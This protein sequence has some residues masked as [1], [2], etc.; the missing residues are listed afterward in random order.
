MVEPSGV[1]YVSKFFSH[2]TISVAAFNP[3]A[4][5]FQNSVRLPQILPKHGILLFSPGVQRDITGYQ[6]SSLSEE[7]IA[8]VARI[9][10]NEY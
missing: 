10:L 9:W 2:I 4:N 3:L 8:K 5:K 1:S 6:S 7:D